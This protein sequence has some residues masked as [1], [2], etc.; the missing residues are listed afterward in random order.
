M[1]LGS[2]TYSKK[3]RGIAPSSS[4][5]LMKAF[6][7][8]QKVRC[9][10]KAESQAAEEEAQRCDSDSG[11]SLPAWTA[12]RKTRTEK[13]SK[14]SAMPTCTL[15]SRQVLE[16]LSCRVQ[17]APDLASCQGDRLRFRCSLCSSS[18]DSQHEAREQ[19]LTH[20]SSGL[21]EAAAHM[22]EDHAAELEALG[23]SGALEG[24][25]SSA[26]RPGG[27]RNM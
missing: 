12:A 14:P 21:Q 5:G 1:C 13:S 26:G 2:G 4:V 10:K 8:M 27:P 20:G 7:K 17:G 15:S 9:H 22:A 11:R 6:C 18:L 25:N 16:V 23:G 24:L 3:F 19:A